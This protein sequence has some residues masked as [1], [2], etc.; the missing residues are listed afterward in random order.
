MGL[1]MC[2]NVRRKIPLETAA[3]IAALYGTTCD[4]IERN[5]DEG[6]YLSAWSAVAIGAALAML[7]A[8][9][10]MPEDAGEVVDAG[11]GEGETACL[12]WRR[13]WEYDAPCATGDSGLDGLCD[14]VRDCEADRYRCR[15]RS[16]SCTEGGQI[17]E[18]ACLDVPACD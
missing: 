4:V 12:E 3:K 2:L 10:P 18:D 7:T 11:R 8:C 5:D 16:V 15:A 14:G 9:G 6:L 1:D 13:A 17:T